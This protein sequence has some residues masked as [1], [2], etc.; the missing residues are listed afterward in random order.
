MVAWLGV[1]GACLALLP[2]Q[3]S[4]GGGLTGLL[5]G[6]TPAVEAEL[7]SVELFGFPLVARTVVV[8]RDPSGSRRTPRPAPWCAPS[9]STAGGPATSPGPRRDPG[10]QHPG[11]VPGLPGDD[12]TSLTYLLFGPDATLGQRTRSAEK[13]AK[14][15]FTERDDVVGVTGSAP[16][17]RRRARSSA[18]PCPGWRRSRC[19]RSC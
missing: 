5:S 18:T 2:A 7:R 10:H 3:T 4:G 14:R 19:W 15:F 12:T 6:D 11:A 9:R 16:A 13:Y 8:Q 1:V 17:R